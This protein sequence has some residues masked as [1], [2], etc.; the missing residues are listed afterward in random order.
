MRT[1]VIGLLLLSTA[2]WAQTNS[3]MMVKAEALS[4]EFSSSRTLAAAVMV[5]PEAPIEAPRQVEKHKPKVREWMLLSA[6]AHTAAGFDAWT[7]RRNVNAGAVELN[8]VLKPF[9]NSNS[10]YAVM[11]AGPTAMD[12]VGW[13]MVRSNHRIYRR[14]WWVP[15]VASA[16]VSVT[17]GINNARNY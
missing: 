10:L 4:S 5:R 7:T 3:V 11:Q 17:C 1:L 2:S 8:A 6:T 15:Q 12:F 13:K 16:A 14:L 9:G